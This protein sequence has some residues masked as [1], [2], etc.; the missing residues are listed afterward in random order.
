MITTEDRIKALEADVDLLKIQITTLS[1]FLSSQNY[2]K[3]TGIVFTNNGI[4]QGCGKPLM[5]GTAS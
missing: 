5:T 2:C 1:N 4:C 3:C